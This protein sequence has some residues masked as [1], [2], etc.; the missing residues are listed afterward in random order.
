MHVCMQV[1]MLTTNV[2]LS[3]SVNHQE[4]NDDSE[5]PH[6]QLIDWVTCPSAHLNILLLPCRTTNTDNTNTNR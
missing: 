5:N 2:S 6:S 1:G 3:S 4:R